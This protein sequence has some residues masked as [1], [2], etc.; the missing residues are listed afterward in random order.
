LPLSASSGDAGVTTE[1]TLRND[2]SPN[3]DVM[4]PEEPTSSLSTPDLSHSVTRKVIF[5]LFKMNKQT[6]SL[7]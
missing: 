4:T 2:F 3:N 7:I 5:N 6:M 1:N